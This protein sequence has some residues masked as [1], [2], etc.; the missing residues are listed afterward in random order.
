MT[1]D[2]RLDEKCAYVVAIRDILPG[3][4]LF[5]DYGRWYWIGKKPVKLSS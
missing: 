5:V 1:F 2:K 3:E 4:E